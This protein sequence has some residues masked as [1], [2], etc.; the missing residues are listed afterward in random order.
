MVRRQDRSRTRRAPDLSGVPADRLQ[1]RKRMLA[2]K[3]YLDERNPRAPDLVGGRDRRRR[4]EPA[5]DR[6]DRNGRERLREVV[7]RGRLTRD[8]RSF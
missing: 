5:Q 7:V 8:D 3:R 2:G 4:V 6:N 1:R